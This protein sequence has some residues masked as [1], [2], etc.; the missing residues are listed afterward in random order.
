MSVVA[1][2]SAALFCSAALRRAPP[3]ARRVRPWWDT[4]GSRA[5]ARAAHLTLPTPAIAAGP[6]DTSPSLGAA[7]I[8]ADIHTHEPALTVV[9]D[10][11][12][13]ALYPPNVAPHVS[14]DPCMQPILDVVLDSVEADTLEIACTV[15][16]ESIIAVR[17]IERAGAAGVCWHTAV[18][19]RSA[20]SGEVTLEFATSE[21]VAHAVEVF[22]E[23]VSPPDAA[24][25]PVTR[26]ASC[27]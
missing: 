4:L 3:S 13:A 24:F 14:P 6:N 9:K 10:A 22:Q 20:K 11:A 5:L 15:Q 8:H 18:A 1:T 7:F 21:V 2:R 25:L 23:I 19:L 17:T 26:F 27:V 16:L 12:W